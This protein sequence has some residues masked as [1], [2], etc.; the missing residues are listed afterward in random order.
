VNVSSVAATV[1]LPVRALYSASKG[2]VSALTRAMA[3]DH[4]PDRIRVNCV[5]PGTADTPWVAR[6]LAR[7]DDPD[8]ELRALSARQPIGRLVSADEVARA[9]GYLAGPGSGSTTGTA[10]PV[11][12]AMASVRVPASS[13]PTPWPVR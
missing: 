2:A 3:A 8:G 4:L 6:L 5:E 12:G 11:D 9:I 7:T 13:E 10:L 1:G